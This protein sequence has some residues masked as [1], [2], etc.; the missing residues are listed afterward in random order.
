VLSDLEIRLSP[1]RCETAIQESDPSAFEAVLVDFGDALTADQ[2]IRGLQLA[3][4]NKRPWWSHS[5][6]RKF[7]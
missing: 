2:V 4:G 7:R 5:S 6:I 1:A 3:P